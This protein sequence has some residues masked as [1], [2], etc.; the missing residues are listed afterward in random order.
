MRTTGCLLL[1]A[2]LIGC[3]RAPTGTSTPTGKSLAQSAAFVNAARAGDLAEVQ[4]IVEATPA[5]IDTHAGPVSKRDARYQQWTALHWAVV[6][7]DTGMIQLLLGHGAATG[8]KD[9]FG[10]QPLHLARSA[11]AASLLI[12]AGAD[13]N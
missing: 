11:Q 1:A 12:D 2:L 5:V 8:V 7:D 4:A 13:V 6:R 10:L 3:Q 9:I